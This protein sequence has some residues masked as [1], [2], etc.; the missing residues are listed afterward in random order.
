MPGSER[1]AVGGE[2]APGAVAQSCGELAEAQPIAAMLIENVHQ[3][4]RE[5]ERPCVDDWYRFSHSCS[6]LPGMLSNRG[7]GRFYQCDCSRL[8]PVDRPARM[9][10]EHAAFHRGQ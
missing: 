3:E 9:T 1:V 7:G 10:L 2:A 6:T 5:R 4:L 8:T